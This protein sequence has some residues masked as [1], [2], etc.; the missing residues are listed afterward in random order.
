ML[1]GLGN[2]SMAQKATGSANICGLGR[3]CTLGKGRTE[4]QACFKRHDSAFPDIKHIRC[5]VAVGAWGVNLFPN[6]YREMN[7]CISKRRQ[8]R[9]PA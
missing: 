8:T 7:G 4:A 6:G 5:I 9:H 3:I 2:S 1:G